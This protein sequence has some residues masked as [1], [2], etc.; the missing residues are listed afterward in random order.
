MAQPPLLLEESFFDIVSLEA[1]PG[2][3]P[4]AEGKPR[5]HGVEMRLGLATV[6]DDPGLWRVSLDMSHK[7]A[8][9]ETPRYRFRLRAIGFFRY[10]A[11]EKPE[12]DIAQL[13]AANGS[14][15]LY[16]SAREYLLLLTSRTPWGQ[17]SLPTMSFADVTLNPEGA[18][19][20]PA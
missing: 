14:S 16:S 6:D 12:A 7:E 2:Y 1:T 20:E 15:I 13:I 8:D 5:R 3:I 4:D 19:S 9:E 11:E 17:L 10:V 18:D